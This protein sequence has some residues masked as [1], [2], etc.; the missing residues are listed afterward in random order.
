MTARPQRLDLEGNR[1]YLLFRRVCELILSPS[2]VT[3]TNALV[4][5]EIFDGFYVGAFERGDR[6]EVH[7]PD[8]IGFFLETIQFQSACVIL[9]FS[10]HSYFKKA[11][12]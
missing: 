7:G 1:C 4:I 10:R 3:F 2:V 11:R 8:Q 5:P 12:P 9:V 6:F